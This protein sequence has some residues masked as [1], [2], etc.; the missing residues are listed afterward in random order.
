VSNAPFV[1]ANAGIYGADWL[2]S[3]NPGYGGYVLSIGTRGGFDGGWKSLVTWGQTILAAGGCTICNVGIGTTTPT[4]T[5]HVVG[6]FTASGAKQFEIPHPL[7][8]Q[9]KRLVHAAIEGPEAAVYYRGQAQLVDGQVIVTLP[10]YFEALTRK[11][12]RTVQLTAI[13][14]WTPLYVDG[15][16]DAGRFIVRTVP[17]GTPTLRFYWEVKAVRADVAPLT[18]ERTV[19]RTAEATDM[20]RR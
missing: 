10:P 3:S 5:L 8:T 4:S 7:D 6:T 16:I 20:S 12:E 9:H 18:V 14:A 19:E 2:A 13:G 11:E 15:E 17:G 1:I